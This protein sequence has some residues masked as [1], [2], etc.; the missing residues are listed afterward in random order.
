MLSVTDTTPP[1]AELADK[2]VN[3]GS[4]V[5]PEDFI[6]S[7]A[8]AS[9]YTVSFFED[10]PPDVFISGEQ[11]VYLVLEDIYGNRSE[12]G[13]VLKV[14][15]NTS[16][17]V[18]YGVRDIEALLGGNV[19]YRADVTAEDSF[20]NPLSY[21]VDSSSVDMDTAGIYEVVYSVTDADGNET[22]EQAFVTVAAVDEETLYKLVDGVLDQIIHEDMTQVEQAR[23]IFNWARNNVGYVSTSPKDTVFEG[24]YRGFRERSGDCFIFYAVSEVM[25]T[26]VGIENMR[27]T[28][29]DGKT[30]HY[31]NLINPDGLGWY[32]FDATPN[33]VRSLDRFMFTDSQAEEYTE[34]IRVE[35]GAINYYNY[36]KD[37]HP[38]VT[39]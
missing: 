22:K 39:P 13:A 25:L 8:D 3:T 29:V 34:R 37:A 30:N 4:M 10:E 31:W 36:D 1:K 19:K 32:H 16:P 14:I 17:P 7:V 12:Y 6:K 38:E 28:R 26:R 35:T 18:F 23:A 21:T 15:P 5:Y 33:Q 11:D 27:V 9:E 24:A 2:T 20:G